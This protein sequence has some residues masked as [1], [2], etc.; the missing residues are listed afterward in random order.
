MSNHHFRSQTSLCSLCGVQITVINK[1]RE[2]PLLVGLSDELR[3]KHPT[4][5]V[6]AWHGQLFFPTNYQHWLDFFCW[7]PAPQKRN[8]LDGSCSSQSHHCVTNSKGEQD[9]KSFCPV[10]LQCFYLLN[11]S[12][13]MVDAMAN[14]DLCDLCDGGL[15]LDVAWRG[16]RTLK[17]SLIT[18][19]CQ[20]S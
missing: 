18:T 14:V 4:R 5:A 11:L 16:R 8:I 1:A 9:S 12:S 10:R 17:L 6:A 7:T 2:A 13:E 20:R 19:A 3:R 15:T